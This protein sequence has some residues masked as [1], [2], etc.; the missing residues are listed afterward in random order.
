MSV[1]VV[2]GAGLYYVTCGSGPLMLM[3]PGANGEAGMFSMLAEHLSEDY[4]VVTYDRRG[5]SRSQLDGPQDYD[6]RLE[7]DADDVRRLIEH[8]S[9][10]PATIFGSSS[11]GVVALET[12]IHHPAVVRTLIPFEPPAVRQLPDG[13]E[14]VDFFIG[15]YDLYRQSGVEPALHKF[16]EKAFAPSDRQIM[17]RARNPKG[18]EFVLPNAIYWFEH[19]LRQYPAVELNL[20][21]LKAH[22]DQ[23]VLLA[24]RESRGYPAYQVNV[25]LAKKL[26]RD[27]IELP[28]GHIS[29]VTQSAEFAREFLLALAQ[30]GHGPR[31]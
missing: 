27:L 1:L 22:A 30:I 13:Q 8:L 11:G 17:A 6:H 2:P 15:L 25:E 5:F 12:L 9:D 24:G 19:E 16:R 20:D 4:T 31:A 29:Y 26:G 28:G 3:V 14:W 23:I 21:V 10:E 7:T 18:G